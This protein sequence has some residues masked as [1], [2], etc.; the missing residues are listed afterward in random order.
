M[1]ANLY[2]NIIYIIIYLH[3][4]NYASH[5]MRECTRCA[6]GWLCQ[7]VFDEETTRSDWIAQWYT[8]W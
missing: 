3:T 2:V 8:W 1:Y 7:G 6:E 5:T 4:Y